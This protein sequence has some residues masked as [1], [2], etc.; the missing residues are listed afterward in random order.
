MSEQTT[1]T[2]TRIKTRTSYVKAENRYK[3]INKS[4]VR[5]WEI[6]RKVNPSLHKCYISINGVKLKPSFEDDTKFVF[7]FPQLRNKWFELIGNTSREVQLLSL[8]DA[9]MYS[10]LKALEHFATVKKE[11][12]RGNLFPNEDLVIYFEP[13][14]NRNQYPK[15]IEIN[16]TYVISDIHFE[17]YGDDA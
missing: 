1:E 15:H 8:E 3:Y 17:K 9:C 6:D 13:V 2:K 4:L 12:F 7:D 11:E 14:L 10:Q 16:E 5:R